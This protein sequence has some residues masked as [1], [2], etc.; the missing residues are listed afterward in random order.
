MFVE[1]S[2]W[3]WPLKMLLQCSIGLEAWVARSKSLES[4]H[5]FSPDASAENN[6]E[7][8]NRSFAFFSHGWSYKDQ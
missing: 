3:A 2:M 1:Y 5:V 6:L 8:S 4:P 7:E